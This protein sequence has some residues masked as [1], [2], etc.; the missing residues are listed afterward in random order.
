MTHSRTSNQQGVTTDSSFR[1]HLRSIPSLVGHPV[2]FDPASHPST[3]QELFLDWFRAAE[4]AGIAEPHAMSVSTIDAEG[5][6][7][8][9]LLVLKDLTEDG[10]WCFAGKR[11]SAKGRQ[12]STTPVAALTFYWR[13]LVRSVRI[14]GRI[15]EAP[16]AETRRDFTARSLDARAIAL[17]GKQSA[18]LGSLDELARDVEE[19]RQRLHQDPAAVPAAWTVWELRPSAVEFWEGSTS[20]LHTR[21]RYDHTSNGWRTSQLRP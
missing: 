7:D 20:R 14:R 21:L 9:R 18:P 10:A 8:T 2:G 15:T 6:P 11:D 17:A 16:E 3:P 1:D 4:E 19:A 12:L 5:V 13:E